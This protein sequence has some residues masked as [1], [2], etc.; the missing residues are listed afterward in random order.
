LGKILSTNPNHGILTQTWLGDL[1]G[2]SHGHFAVL[3]GMSA[4]KPIDGK[5]TISPSRHCND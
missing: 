4:D 3:V 1:C 2:P 5:I